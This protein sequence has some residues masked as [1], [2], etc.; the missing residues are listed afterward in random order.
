MAASMQSPDTQ[1]LPIAP[2]YPDINTLTKWAGDLT[3][4]LQQNLGTISRRANDKTTVPLS[5][6]LDAGG[7]DITNIGNLGNI[8]G[9]I[10]YQ[11]ADIDTR[12]VNVTGDTM[13]GELI[14]PAATTGLAPIRL[15]HG[16]APSAPVNGQ[17]WTT[18]AAVFARLNSA[19]KTLAVLESAQTFT[20]AQTFATAASGQESII[21]PHGA[22]PSAPTNG[23]IW[24][25]TTAF[26]NRTNG[27][28]LTFAVLETS[29]TFAGNNTFSG[30]NTFSAGV[31][32][33]I[34]GKLGVG[35]NTG[36]PAER[37][38][39][40]YG[41]N[42]DMS[43]GSATNM[44]SYWGT[45][46]NNSVVA[47]NRRVSDGN[48]A[49]ASFPTADFGFFLSSG[50]AQIRFST[51][52]TNGSGLSTE[53]LRINGAGFVSVLGGS[54]GQGAPVTKSA[55]FTVAATENNLINTK[56]GSACIVTLPAA[57]S[58]VGREILIKNTSNQSITSASANVIP[59]TGGAA[60][61]TITNSTTGRW[62]KLVSDGTNWVIMAQN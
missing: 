16:V 37:L 10:T 42:V 61:T 45:S 62:V 33:A 23:S 25:T 4:T 47:I 54:F 34:L 15:P 27:A 18:T 2:T 43:V 11:G 41:E 3:R 60:G 59:L 35:P 28:T 57:S 44:K 52:S 17:L 19:T 7:F 49:S 55:D 8:S 14:L 31:D 26:F 32:Q 50:D 5:G 13:T 58:F 48:Y 40:G 24:S 53:R 21:I 9:T 51:S 56:T 1:I 12:Y 30:A 36:T 6:P 22:A 39:V 20:A 46:N 38:S 29:Q